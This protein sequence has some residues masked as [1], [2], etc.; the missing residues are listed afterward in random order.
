MMHIPISRTVYQSS[1]LVQINLLS[2]S[3]NLKMNDKRTNP[4]ST[5][6]IYIYIYHQQKD[7]INDAHS[8]TIAGQKK[9]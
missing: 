6:Y 1:L 5:L 7:G 4:K 9:V 8:S 3:I 2:Q